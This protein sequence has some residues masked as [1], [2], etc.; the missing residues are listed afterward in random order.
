MKGKIFTIT[1]IF[2]LNFT[3]ALTLNAQWAKSYGENGEDTANSIQ[4]T[5]DGGYIVAGI[6]SS[7]GAG[8]SDMWILKLASDGSIE[9]QKTYGGDSLDEAQFVQQT[10]DGGYIVAGTTSSFGAGSSDMW[11]LKLASNGAIEWQRTYGESQSESAYSIQQT[12]DGGYIAA[13]NTSSFGS[14]QL[15]FWIIKLSTLGDMEWNK[16]Y[17]GNTSET[18][19]SVKQTFDGGYVVAGTTASFGAGSLDMWVLKLAF[20]GTAEWQR[21]FGGEESEGANSIQQTIDGGYIV[22]GNI[23]SSGVGLFDYWIIKLSSL[24]D[25]EWNKTY[26]GSTSE[27]GYSIQQTFDGGYVV[28][29]TTA[30]FGAGSFDMWILK[31]AFDGTIEWQKTCGGSQADEVS[32]IEETVEGG[33]VVAGSTASYG[34]GA[35]DFLILKLL[36][37]GDLNPFC[38]FLNVSD[39]GVSESNTA[40]AETFADAGSPDTLSVP[41]NISPQESE[42][43]VYDLCSAQQTL[44]M[45]S[46]S[47][48]TTFPPP[49]TYVYDFA[50]RVRI[51]AVPVAGFNFVMWSGDVIATDSMLFITLDSDKSIQANFSEHILEELWEEVKRAPCFIATAAFGS[52]LHPYVK[53]LQDFRDRYLLP[54]PLGRKFV[55]LYYKY[56]PPF[57]KLITNHKSLRTVV[58][59][60]LVPVVVLGYTTVLFGPVKT[61]FIFVLTLM[62]FLYLGW[63]YRR[64]RT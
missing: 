11:I 46:S 15:D 60:W 43:V 8:S 10:T 58:R 14:G 20:D 1:I 25:M 63:I 39:A 53:T 21:T 32:F 38:G 62:P 44:I 41:S 3:F 51:S 36:A 18:G 23:S 34:V 31:L 45:S 24:G 13:G 61:F 30:S 33:F 27:T 4:Q 64:R 42:A 54:T 29:G 50:E 6:T 22:A 56:S 2:F 37:N 40:A 26:G 7:F 16:T 12:N 49:G 57:A 59:V 35:R 48:G 28:A 55:N 5:S 52:P 17:G 9:W 19:Y 47:G